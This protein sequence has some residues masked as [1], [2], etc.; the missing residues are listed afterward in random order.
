MSLITSDI[1]PSEKLTRLLE[2]NFRVGPNEDGGRDGPLGGTNVQAASD[3]GDLRTYLPGDNFR[4]VLSE[5]ER[6]FN[7]GGNNGRVG[8]GSD[9]N[10]GLLGGTS[11][12]SPRP[13]ECKLDHTQT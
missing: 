11:Y 1:V 9:N 12:L 3:E 10:G 6:D 8:P 7:Q 5:I 4:I 13:I 2:N